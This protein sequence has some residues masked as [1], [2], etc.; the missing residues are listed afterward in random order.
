MERSH[1]RQESKLS[2]ASTA[3]IILLNGV[4]SSGKGSIARALQS[5]TAD[6][7]LHVP[8]DTFM[9]MLPD[10]YQEHPDGFA[11]ESRAEEGKPVVEITTG[12]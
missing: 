10:A 6:P 9:E 8:M 1:E 11:Y 12:P 5:I 7:F 2:P 3:R 4:G